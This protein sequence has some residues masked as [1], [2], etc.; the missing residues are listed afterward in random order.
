MSFLGSA[1]GSVVS[2]AAGLFAANRA[3]QKNVEN[4][5]HRHQWEVEDLKKAGLNPVLSA[6]GGGSVAAAP[7]ANISDLGKSLSEGKQLDINDKVGNSTI[8]TNEAVSA[9]K[10]SARDLNIR[11]GDLVK[12]NIERNGVLN[13]IDTLN[14]AANV[15]YLNTQADVLYGRLANET[16]LT[17]SQI[18]YYANLGVAAVEN[19]RARTSEVGSANEYRTKQGNYLGNITARD[20]PESDMYNDNPWLPS[21]E[22]ILDTVGRVV[23]IGGKA[24][25]MYSRPA[26]TIGF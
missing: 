2:S 15:H 25:G 10:Y 6:N 9:E 22:K 21:A 14:S 17:G 1:A 8:K 5:Q 23:G 11:Q 16:A 4:Y 19:A 20:K 24:G 12:S 18:E 3:N 13:T 7:M 26:N